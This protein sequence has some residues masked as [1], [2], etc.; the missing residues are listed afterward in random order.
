MRVGL[1]ELL[2]NSPDA[3]RLYK[4]PVGVEAIKLVQMILVS[5]G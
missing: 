2:D 5:C 4:R 3:Y 1:G